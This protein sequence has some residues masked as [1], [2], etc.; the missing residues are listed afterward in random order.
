MVSQ[1]EPLFGPHLSLGKIF[2]FLDTFYVYDAKMRI[3]CEL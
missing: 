3:R 2:P 1:K